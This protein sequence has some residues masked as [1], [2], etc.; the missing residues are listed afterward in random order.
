MAAAKRQVPRDP[1]VRTAA[2]IRGRELSPGFLAS[3][4]RL[5]ADDATLK[6]VTGQ[7]SRRRARFS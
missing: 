7:T 1:S 3:L 5:G 2:P 6:L 4:R